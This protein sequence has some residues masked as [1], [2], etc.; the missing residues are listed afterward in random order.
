M[1]CS[2]SLLEYMAILSPEQNG[3]PVGPFHYSALHPGGGHV[4]AALSCWSR[5]LLA[6]SLI[7][8]RPK[9]ASLLANGNKNIFTAY[10]GESH[11][12]PLLLMIQALLYRFLKYIKYMG[13]I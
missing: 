10:R 12:T 1:G 2:F 4:P 5:A 6:F 9:A 7:A 3:S 8:H 11:I 13:Y